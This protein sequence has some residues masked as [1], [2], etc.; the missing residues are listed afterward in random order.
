MSRLT[1]SSQD[2]RAEARHGELY[3]SVIPVVGGFLQLSFAVFRKVNNRDIPA[4]GHTL[5]EVIRKDNIDS[6]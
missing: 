4:F 3:R 2:Y 5:C 6:H 1:Y